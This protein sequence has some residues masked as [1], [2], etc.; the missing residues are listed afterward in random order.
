MQHFLIQALW[1]YSLNISNISK[2]SSCW[3]Y[4]RF[5]S[6]NQMTSYRNS[7]IWSQTEENVLLFICGGFR[8]EV[9]PELLRMIVPSVIYI[10][11]TYLMHFKLKLHVNKH[12]TSYFERAA[13]MRYEWRPLVSF[14]FS[15]LSMWFVT[16]HVFY[17]NLLILKFLVNK[18]T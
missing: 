17:M 3:L 8:S 11:V 5:T 14:S 10:H 12:L 15:N 9:S 7:F 18:S 4:S 13:I 16:K 2:M 6:L 1:S